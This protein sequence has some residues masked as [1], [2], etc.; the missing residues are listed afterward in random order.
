[1]KLWFTV[2]IFFL[3][4]I[5]RTPD[6]VLPCGKN[7]DK[8]VRVRLSSGDTMKIY[9]YFRPHVMWF[10]KNISKY[11]DIAIFTAT[12]ENYAAPI[13]DLLDSNKKYIQGQFYREN[14]LVT[15]SHYLIKDLRIFKER[16]PK[17]ILIVDNSATCFVNHLDNGVPIIPFYDNKADTQLLSLYKFLVACSEKADSR[18][19]I[20]ETFQ[21]HKYRSY[22][23]M[24]SLFENM[25]TGV[26][27]DQTLEMSTLKQQKP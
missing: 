8:M 10:L 19:F 14:C 16:D 6:E 15:D 5:G 13:I 20:R 27:C 18:E 3:L 2:R 21:W 22:P 12:T 25:F 17:D 23:D 7:H 1:M 11:Y 9:V 24:D 4:K 26:D